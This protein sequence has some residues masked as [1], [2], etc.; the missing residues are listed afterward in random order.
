M[1]YKVSKA[2]KNEV[3]I[4]VTLD[5]AEW[6]QEVDNAYNKHKNEYPV[7]GFRKGKVP[8]KVIE[9][10]YGPTVFFEEA[11]AE[12]FGKAYTQVLSK[13][14][15][16]DPVDAPNLSVKSL[17]DK[18]IVIVAVVPV[19]P[20]VKLGAYK[21][22]HIHHEP[23]KIT[24]KD[25]DAELERVR[26]QNVRFVEKQGVIE[27]GDIA[28]I[29]FAGYDGKVQFEGGTAEG[30][31]LEIGSHSFID[32][33]EDQLLGHKAGDELDVKV[34]FPANYQ[35]KELAG[36][37]VVFKVKVNVVKSKELPQ[38]NDAFASDVS[39]FETLQ[40]YKE[41]IKEHLGEHAVE[42][43]KVATENEII[44]AIVKDTQVDVPHAL[45][46]TE[47]DNIMHDI[48]YRLMYQG[49]KLEDYA[50]YLGK[51]VAEL[52]KEREAD[53][54]KGVKVRLV[55]QEIV[56]AENIAVEKAEIDEKIKELAKSAKK[57]IK[58]YKET[59]T[60]ERISYLRNDILVNKLLTFL[61][62]NNK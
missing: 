23:K 16:I 41:H 25:V 56:K 8:R 36:K 26:A 37:P 54:T 28:N 10:T 6:E 20:E 31:D 17:D 35:A 1:K 32:N 34:T 50:K 43:A 19:M 42:D 46:E 24:A 21:G 52:R 29:D 60:E 49:L 38:L 48:E 40:A 55:M 5:I 22:L 15:D 4:E 33:F 39:E 12:G 62:E 44:E 57:T 9:N 61:V 3:S 45:V 14:K 30:Y 53:A 2:K 51:T 47:L 27:A 58:E 18:G 13:E 7:E 11:I 59:L